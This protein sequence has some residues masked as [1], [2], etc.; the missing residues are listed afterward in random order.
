MTDF[1]L[2]M[3]CKQG[4]KKSIEMLFSRYKPLV[5]KRYVNLKKNKKYLDFDEDDYV[6]ES[7]FWFL[8]AVRYVDPSKIGDKSTWKFLGAFM[9][10]SKG[11]AN[12]VYKIET[13]KSKYSSN[14]VDYFSQLPKDC[15]DF[16]PVQETII[17]TYSLSAHDASMQKRVVSQF[18]SRLDSTE[19]K[20]VLA[21]CKSVNPKG[22]VH[23]HRAGVYANVSRERI[24]QVHG[25]L[26][27]KF[28]KACADNLH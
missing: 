2:V 8:K 23:L 13:V 21:L 15:I 20:R 16:E 1:E 6:Q 7:Y 14:K 25:K 11:Q 28:K 26:A 5:L 22:K 12:R 9:W 24:R 17:D 27:I 19:K 10:Y 4:D 18:W 3:L